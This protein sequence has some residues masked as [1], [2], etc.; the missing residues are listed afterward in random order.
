MTLKMAR[1]CKEEHLLMPVTS[2]VE[3]IAL[4][5]LGTHCLEFEMASARSWL[6]IV[7]GFG[8]ASSLALHQVQ[9]VLG[10]GLSSCLARPAVCM[11]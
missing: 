2:M 1:D 5:L 6:L 8:L 3:N 11:G 10:V 4:L 7:S 9:P